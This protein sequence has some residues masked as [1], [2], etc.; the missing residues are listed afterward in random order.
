MSAP[1]PSRFR[2][3]LLA[4]GVLIGA[5]AAASGLLAGGFFEAQVLAQEESHTAELVR[6]Q[7]QQHL[8]V[9]AFAWPPPEHAPGFRTFLEGLPGVFR[10]KAFDP[11]GRIVW[12]DEPRLIGRTFPDNA[13][14]ATA[15][16]GRV[17]T[18]LESPRRPEHLY[19]RAK[20]HVAEAY[21]PITLP[22][23]PGVIGV[24]ETYKDVTDVVAGIR[25]ARRAIWVVAG[26]LGALLYLALAV[27][28]RRAWLNERRAITRLGE[29][30][31]ALA[32]KAA[33]LERANRA[34]HDAQAQLVE[35]E[36]MAAVGEVVV[37]LHHAILNP[38]TGI[39]GALEVLK[40]ESGVRAATRTALTEAE[41]EVRKVEQ[42]V[43][44]L[45]TMRRVAG[46]PYVGDTL[47]LD[48]KRSC[49]PDHSAG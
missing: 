47:M 17:V 34:L 49:D 33:D 43:R 29:S 37:S 20:D 42:L 4:S 22:G 19:E 15:L 21:V 28:V 6:S 2:G 39:L 23:R 26:G 48:L 14:L 46:T 7:A 31:A 30:H 44:R 25:R 13:Y 10:I 40:R 9:G 41:H 5:V 1:R 35:K 12:S 32:A 27:V 24:I 45:P 36:R 8:A 11:E 38:L 18:V 3:F 16:T